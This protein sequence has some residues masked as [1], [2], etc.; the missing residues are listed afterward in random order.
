MALNDFRSILQ[1]TTKFEPIEIYNSARQ[2]PVG[3]SAGVLNLFEAVRFA[4]KRIRVYNAGSGEAFGD[5]GKEPANQ[6]TAFRPGSL[7]AVAKAAGFG[8]R[9]ITA[10]PMIYLPAREYYLIMNHH[11]APSALQRKK[12][13]V[14]PKS[15]RQVI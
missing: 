7:Y 14:A 5:T 3:L 8:K 1:I 6:E 9:Q 11:Y 12:L 10:K 4:S 15:L 2:T 13:S